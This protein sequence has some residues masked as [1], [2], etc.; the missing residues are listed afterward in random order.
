MLRIFSSSFILPFDVTVYGTELQN[1]LNTFEKT[2]GPKL[3]SLNISLSSLETIVA[4]FKTETI[5]FSKRLASI[6]RK[7]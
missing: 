2:N 6:D 1:Y 3:K 7:K 5:D 4:K